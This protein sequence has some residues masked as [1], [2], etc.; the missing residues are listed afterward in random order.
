MITEEAA[1]SIGEHLFSGETAHV[2]AVLDG[3]SVPN[4]LLRLFDLQPDFECLY[5]GDLAPDMAEV[6][7]YLVRLDPDSEFAAW[8]IEEGWG[9][10]WG[11]F[12]QSD[13]DLRAMRRHFRTFLTITGPDGKSRLF[14]Y[15]DPRVLRLYLPTCNAQELATVFGPVVCYILEDA[16][17]NQ[18]L[19]FQNASGSLQEEKKILVQE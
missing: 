18:L 19:R 6:A 7:P 16:E 8:L 3:A 13:A 12:A 14:R 17:A 9:K 10:H 2:Y 4:L 11:I 1:Q 15:Y 5:R